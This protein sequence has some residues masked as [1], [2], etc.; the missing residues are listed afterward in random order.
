MKTLYIR[1]VEKEDEGFL[2]RKK[3]TFLE[4]KWLERY[5]KTENISLFMVEDRYM[6]EIISKVEELRQIPS[7]YWEKNQ[8]LYWK[9]PFLGYNEEI[10]WYNIGTEGIINKNI[11]WLDVITNYRIMEYFFH[12][13]LANTIL[14]FAVDDIVIMNRHS[15]SQSYSIGN[16]YGGRNTIMS[17]RNSNTKSRT[18]G[19]VIIMHG[20][21]PFIT[22]HQVSDPQG[23]KN[24]IKSAKKQIYG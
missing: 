22:F 18:I 15:S 1:K 13:H 12:N 16:Y 8:S 19:D 11:K 24:L 10:L 17:F 5:S 7:G 20:G 3:R 4:L 23:I 2:G 21:K 14:L 6:N 9:T